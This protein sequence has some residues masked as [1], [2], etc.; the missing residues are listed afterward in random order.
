M[1]NDITIVEDIIHMG[2]GVGPAI[3]GSHVLWVAII[4]KA[5]LLCK[6]SGIILA[7]F[8]IAIDE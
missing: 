3:V 2:L 8:H 6:V 4:F 7:T 5:C 1:G